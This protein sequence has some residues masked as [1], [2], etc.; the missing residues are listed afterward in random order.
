L[1]ILLSDAL[2]ALIL[3]TSLNNLQRKEW[4]H[5]GFHQ[6]LEILLLT[7]IKFKKSWSVFSWGW[8]ISH[9]LE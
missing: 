9:C 6:C 7:V 8:G 5:Y 4:C 3:K 1:E 2:I